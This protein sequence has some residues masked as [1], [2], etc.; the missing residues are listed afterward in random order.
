MEYLLKMVSSKRV[1]VRRKVGKRY[2]NKYICRTLR[3]SGSFV[4]MWGCLKSDGSRKLVRCPQRLDSTSYELVLNKG[5]KFR[6]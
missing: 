6:L 3:F 1:Y 4:M 5:L 2:N